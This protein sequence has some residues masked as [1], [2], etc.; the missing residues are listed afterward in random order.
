MAYRCKGMDY[1]LLKIESAAQ[2]S[3]MSMASLQF[4]LNAC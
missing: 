3:T 2:E 4:I 1:F